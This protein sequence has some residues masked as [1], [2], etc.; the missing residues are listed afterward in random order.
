M[1]ADRLRYNFTENGIMTTIEPPFIP[2]HF[3]DIQDMNEGLVIS[4]KLAGSTL[5]LVPHVEVEVVW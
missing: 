2:S 4:T 3:A 5:S 1:V